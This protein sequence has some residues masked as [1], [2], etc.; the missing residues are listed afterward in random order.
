VSSN[1]SNRAKKKLH[2]VP[3]RRPESSL[4]RRHL[5]ERK[6]VY[7]SVCPTYHPSLTLTRSLFLPIPKRPSIRSG[8]MHGA[9]NDHIT[10]LSLSNSSHRGCA[11]W[12]PETDPMLRIL[13]GAVRNDQATSACQCV[14]NVIEASCRSPATLGNLHWTVHSRLGFVNTFLSRSKSESPENGYKYKRSLRGAD[15]W[16]VQLC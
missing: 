3:H 14:D 10:T 12:H 8:G 13:G 15:G 5:F 16:I 11:G 1:Q 2:R 6:T 4:C 9:A 7:R